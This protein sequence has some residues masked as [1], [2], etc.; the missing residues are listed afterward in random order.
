LVI[1]KKSTKKSLRKAQSRISK[2][3]LGGSMRG[4]GDWERKGRG[5]EEKQVRGRK[6][7]TG[8]KRKTP[9]KKTPD[10]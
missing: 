10:W 3:K 8:E 5:N 9:R 1:K 6:T 2:E 4:K 7:T